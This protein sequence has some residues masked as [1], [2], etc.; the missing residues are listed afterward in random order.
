MSII[1]FDTASRA[2]AAKIV[3]R[4]RRKGL[5]ARIVARIIEAR[6]RQ[7]LDLIRRHGVKLPHELEQAGWKI[8]ERSEDSLPFVR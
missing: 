4:A 1:T 7:A 3:A 5:F 8:N 2:R 6:E